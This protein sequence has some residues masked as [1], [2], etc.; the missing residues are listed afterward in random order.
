MKKIIFTVLL[1]II[2]LTGYNIYSSQDQK[3]VSE[4]A[5]ANVEALAADSEASGAKV[6]CYTSFSYEL[7]SSVV[8]CT[9]CTTRD[10]ET[11]AWYNI[12]DYCMTE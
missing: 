7:G 5:L 12:H 2:V 9:T 8:D 3:A 6:K 10:N 11:D 4:L 1:A